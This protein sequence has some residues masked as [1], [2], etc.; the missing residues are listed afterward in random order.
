MKKFMVALLSLALIF[1]FAFL[2]PSFGASDC[3]ETEDTVTIVYNEYVEL[4]KLKEKSDKELSF[5]NYDAIEIN[6]IRMIDYKKELEDR[7]SLSVEQLANMGYTDQQIGV[8][9]SYSGSEMETVTLAA[10]LT[11][12]ITKGTIAN[13]NYTYNASTDR[14]YWKNTYTWKWDVGP[15]FMGNDTVAAG[16]APTMSLSAGTNK[17][18]YKNNY[19]GASAGSTSQSFSL[20]GTNTIQCKNFTMAKNLDTSFRPAKYDWAYKGSGYVTATGATQI[21]DLQMEIAYGH[22]TISLS[23]SVSAPWGIGFSFNANVDKIGKTVQ[24]YF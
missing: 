4:E 23:P 11:L 13:G 18:Y 14:C 6:K 12:S 19:T 5:M 3:A 16:W 2:A 15:L 10:T 1:N 8:L 7:A 22:A 24:Y 17:T 9:K 21:R 20:K